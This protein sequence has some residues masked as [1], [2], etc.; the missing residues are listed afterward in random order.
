MLLGVTFKDEAA[1]FSADGPCPK[2]TPLGVVSLVKMGQV[3][4]FISWR[5]CR[6][7]CSPSPY[8]LALGSRVESCRNWSANRRGPMLESNLDTDRNHSNGWASRAERAQLLRRVVFLCRWLNTP[9]VPAP[10]VLLCI[11]RGSQ[12]IR[13]SWGQMP[14]GTFL[15]FVP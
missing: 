3:F 1:M 7:T 10:F 14:W 8:T 11:F 9:T 2:L 4:Q 5:Y 15:R 13:T 12:E 6:C